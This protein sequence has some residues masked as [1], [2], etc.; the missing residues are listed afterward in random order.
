M[1]IPRAGEK[2]LYAAVLCG[3]VTS[4]TIVSAGFHWLWFSFFGGFSIL[5]SAA[6]FAMLFPAP[7]A[8]RVDG[9]TWST[10]TRAVHRETGSLQPTTSSNTT[11]S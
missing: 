4:L 7:E 5:V 1:L 11:G 8:K 6:L 2:A 9:L 3:V 10:R